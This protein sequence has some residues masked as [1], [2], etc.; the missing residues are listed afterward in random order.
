MYKNILRVNGEY[1]AKAQALPVNTSAPGNGGPI[2]AHNTQG[3]L[4]LA[5]VAATQVGFTAG[6][7]L[8][9]TVQDCDTQSGSYA[10][11]P[12]LFKKTFVAGAN[13]IKAGEVIGVL[14]LASDVRPFVKVKLTTDDAAPSG[15]VDVFTTYLPR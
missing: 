13:T 9:V 7:S 12:V 10:D 11:A 5:L 15:T 6:K 2:R 3:A 8:T 1:L 14:P 4:E